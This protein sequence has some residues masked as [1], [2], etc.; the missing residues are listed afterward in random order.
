MVRAVSTTHHL[1]L[2]L[3]FLQTEVTRIPEST[4]VICKSIFNVI[5]HFY[6]PKVFVSRTFCE[7]SP[8]YK[9]NPYL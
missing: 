2:I 5:S 1:L 7:G 9:S 8:S 3:S 4:F 6:K